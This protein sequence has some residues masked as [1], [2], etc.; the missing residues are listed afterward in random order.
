M[1]A[2]NVFIVD[3]ELDLTDENNVKHV[4]YQLNL[5]LKSSPT[6]IHGINTN[7]STKRVIAGVDQ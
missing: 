1:E 4:M 3:G 2:P 5:F 7:T 6:T